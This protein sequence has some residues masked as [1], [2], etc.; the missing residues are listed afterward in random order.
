MNGILNGI[1]Y[2]IIKTEPEN[3]SRKEYKNPH[4]SLSFFL[5]LHNSVAIIYKLLELGVIILDAKTEG[6][7]SQIFYLGPSSFFYVI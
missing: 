2:I 7:V 1:F 6:T 3:I 5:I 4:F